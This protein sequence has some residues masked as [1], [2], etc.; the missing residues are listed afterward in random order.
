MSTLNLTGILHASKM[1]AALP[2]FD[3]YLVIELPLSLPEIDHSLKHRHQIAD[4]RSKQH[5]KNA[6]IWQ[7]GACN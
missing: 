3:M 1:N 2:T 7:G 4:K 5:L 6:A